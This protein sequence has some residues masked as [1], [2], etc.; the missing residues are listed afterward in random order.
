MAAYT[1]HVHRLHVQAEQWNHWEKLCCFSPHDRFSPIDCTRDAL[2]V[3]E[4]PVRDFPRR[5]ANVDG[6]AA[7]VHWQ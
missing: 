4:I 3:R 2:L 1:S 6:R 7:P 5:S